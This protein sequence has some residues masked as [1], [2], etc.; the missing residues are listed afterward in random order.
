MERNYQNGK[1]YC[2][3]NNIDDDIY[4]GSTTQS[5]SRRMS[6]HRIDM[7]SERTQNYKLY[8][9]MRE[10]GQHAFYIELIEEFKM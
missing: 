3:R 9:K 4:V 7:N 8:R 1:I 6:K 5:L 2:I 10:L